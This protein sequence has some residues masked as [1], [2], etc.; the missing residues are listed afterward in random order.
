MA[1]QE[2]RCVKRFE[3]KEVQRARLVKSNKRVRACGWQ[4]HHHVWPQQVWNM[5]S[6]V[7]EPMQQFVAEG[8]GQMEWNMGFQTFDKASPQDPPMMEAQVKVLCQI[9]KKFV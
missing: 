2:R 4:V 8:K 6:A 1:K 5:Y 3:K 9:K 7:G